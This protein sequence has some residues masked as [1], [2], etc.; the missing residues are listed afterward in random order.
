M[1]TP[2]R[3]IQASGV[4]S[5]RTVDDF[6]PPDVC[7]S[8]YLAFSQVQIPSALFYVSLRALEAGGFEEELA[9]YLDKPIACFVRSHLKRLL[10]HIPPSTVADA[11]GFELW[12]NSGT[13]RE[14]K[15]VYLH[16]DNDEGLRA[17]SGIVQTP[18]VGSILHLGPR[19]GL[20]GGETAFVTEPEMCTRY[21]AFA[22]YDWNTL[23]HQGAVEVV[24]QR[25][26]R[27]VLFSGDV[28]HGAVSVTSHPAHSPRIAF[29]ANLWHKRI[30]DVPS[31]ICTMS[32]A[33]FR[34]SQA[35]PS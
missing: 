12:T 1:Q 8:M 31:G 2:P 7:L 27:L 4:G 34:V 19:Q 26:G 21:P 13:V 22:K 3:V 15:E 35:S 16:L 30:S 20:V 17:A 25:A 33:D 6:W 5:V 18:L 29:L 11:D 28:A 10:D 23:I 9:H 24:E 32:A 14:R